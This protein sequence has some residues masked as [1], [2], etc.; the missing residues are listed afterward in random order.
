MESDL[1]QS[2]IQ[3]PYFDTNKFQKQ[4]EL[5]K[6]ASDV[7]QK[8][9][10]HYSAHNEDVLRAID[11]VED[12]LRDRHRLCY[13]GQAINAHLPNKYKIYNPEYSIPDYDFFT[14]DQASDI[15]LLVKNLRKAGFTEISAREG[16]HEG[17]VKIYVD[18]VPVADIT[19]IDNKLYKILSQREFRYDGISYLDANTL[20][21]LMY[22][23]LSRP[24]G[25]VQRW[26]KVYE[27]LS[28]FNEFV[29]MKQCHT[30]QD[31]FKE[32]LSS[33]QTEYVINYIIQNRRLFAGSDLINYYRQNLFGKQRNISWIIN[34]KK[35]IIFLSPDIDNDAKQIRNYFSE[36]H[37]SSNNSSKHSNYTIKSI[38]Y[39]GAE[40][41]PTLKIVR[42]KN[43]NLVFIIKQDACL[44]YFN[45]SID[46]NKLLKI[47]SLDTLIT[48]YFSL[49]LVKSEYMNMGSIEC[50]A[51]ELVQISIKAR[52]NP[53]QFPFPF[54][55]IKCIGHQ[56]SLPS[57]IRA[58][59]K[60]ITQK[61][62]NL[63]N[64]I[65]NN[66]MS[67][68]HNKTIRNSHKRHTTKTSSK[69]TIF[70]YI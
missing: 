35:P 10:D 6:N 46:Q 34:N 59:V 51:N 11:V 8:K 37:T 56:Q 52:K 50:L 60:R 29:H 61:R 31:I 38:S 66:S 45:V 58:K 21:M 20:R 14:P 1:G 3:S 26:E 68:K 28:L 27:R 2:V 17:T 42:Y 69:T 18:F 13:G 39:K 48:L 55:S 25:E 57:L 33:N 7:A 70:D 44:S 47:A 63:Q 22:L 40:L 67:K 30:P 5:I 9:I 43:R 41:I 65:R 49:G 24:R 36:T 12:F 64:L 15:K 54:I 16:M 32:G 62:K 53:E 4:I 23:E 19:A